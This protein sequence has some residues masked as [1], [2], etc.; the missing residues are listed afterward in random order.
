MGWAGTGM[1][2]R[3][4]KRRASLSPVIRVESVQMKCPA[5]GGTGRLMARQCGVQ[6]QVA[7]SQS[8]CGGK[9]TLQEEAGIRG[10]GLVV[11]PGQ[12]IVV[13]GPG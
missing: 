5:V 10:E 8:G 13:G 3:D 1:G 6:R 4:A 9:D 7:G 12:A 2:W 11:P